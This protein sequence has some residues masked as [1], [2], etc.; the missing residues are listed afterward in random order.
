M[1]AVFV[2]AYAQA[3]TIYLKGN[4]DGTAGGN[5]NNDGL[6]SENAV[7]TLK[8][9][10]ELAEPGGTIIVAKGVSLTDSITVENV[11]IER[12]AG[13]KKDLFVIGSANDMPT[14]TIQNATID[15]MGYDLGSS[16]YAPLFLIN[17]GTLQLQEGAV[18]RNNRSTAVVV[19]NGKLEMNGGEI[20]NNITGG[21]YGSAVQLQNNLQNTQEFVMTGGSIH[22]NQQTAY[23]GTVSVSGEN[24]TFTMQGGSIS[25]NTA[26]YG[27]GV[28]VSNGIANLEGGTIS[29]N[30][31]TAGGGGVYLYTGISTPPVCNLSGTQI[32]GNKSPSGS[33]AGIYACGANLYMTGGA[34]TNNTCGT[35]GAGIYAYAH[36]YYN[37]N[38]IEISGG[39]ISGNTLSNSDSGTAIAVYDDGGQYSNDVRLHGAPTIQGNIYLYGSRQKPISVTGAL[40]LSPAVDIR[41]EKAPEAGDELVVYADGLTPNAAQFTATYAKSEGLA[42]TVDGQK[43]VLG[44]APAATIAPISPGEDAGPLPADNLP[45][46]TAPSVAQEIAAEAGERAKMAVTAVNV[47]TYQWY[48][49]RGDGKGYVA[50]SG[51][52]SAMYETSPVNA[53]NDGYKYICVVTNEHGSETSPV[54]T[55]RVLG[56]S[57]VPSTGDGAPLAAWVALLALSGCGAALLVGKRRRAHR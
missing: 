52:T 33:G 37:N 26:Q 46:I 42:V 44:I 53:G 4:A 21:N 3:A 48:V 12:D 57:A 18:L 36:E 28:E 35:A 19:V 16:D 40:T 13:F 51:A 27:G 29:G 49:D 8:K 30:T 2:P 22:D 25:G 11:T 20:C 17:G 38:I 41:R 9:A 7:L 23:C 56:A 39:T 15:G 10:L 55:L 54:F 32:T 31:A 47:G 6:T 24:A 45:H 43:L 1:S 14:I 5:D 50:L 34:I